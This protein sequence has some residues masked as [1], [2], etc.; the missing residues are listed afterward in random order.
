MIRTCLF[1]ILA[2]LWTQHSRAENVFILVDHSDSMAFESKQQEARTDFLHYYQN[3]SSVHSV[4]VTYFGGSNGGDCRSEVQISEPIPKAWPPPKSTELSAEGDNPLLSAIDSI[5]NEYGQDQIRIIVISD[6]DAVCGSSKSVC[7]AVRGYETHHP[8]ISF[9]FEPV[10]GDSDPSPLF[11]CLTSDE[12]S[13]SHPPEHVGSG[14]CPICEEENSGS[15]DE[16]HW[17]WKV[18]WAIS[19]ALILCTLIVVALVITWFQ[20]S[21]DEIDAFDQAAKSNTGTTNQINASAPK[22]IKKLLCTSIILN[23]IIGIVFLLLWFCPLSNILHVWQAIYDWTNTR[24]GTAVFSTIL[25]GYIAW[26]AFTV[27]KGGLKRLSSGWTQT[28]NELRNETNANAV[29]DLL[30]E[31]EVSR[32]DALSAAET[33]V[34]KYRSRLDEPSLENLQALLGELRDAYETILSSVRAHITTDNYKA[35]KKRGFSQA[36]KLIEQ[37]KR[38]ADMSPNTARVLRQTL[39]EWKKKVNALPTLP[40]RDD[41]TK[42]I[43]QK[44]PIDT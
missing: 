21:T 32:D 25:G 23:A 37:L 16:R 6:F 39:S 3:V 43:S 12:H 17:L 34:E 1:A 15:P 27:W 22:K 14:S 20:H 4:S 40:P 24:F 7:M 36:D 9:E 42:G 18:S 26:I 8:N 13:K 2:I 41:P 29:R 35:W 19:I 38:D 5:Y 33:E 11:E 10:A 31:L 30:N 28:F 44:N